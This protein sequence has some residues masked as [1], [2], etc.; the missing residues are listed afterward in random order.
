VW[1]TPLLKVASPASAA[2]DVDDGADGQQQLLSRLNAVMSASAADD[3]VGGQQ[4]LPSPR[5]SQHAAATVLSASSCGTPPAVEDE[6]KAEASVGARP[7]VLSTSDS[8]GGP[9]MAEG[10]GN[11]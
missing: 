8:R 6:F 7:V 2:S 10:F 11:A 3:D 9:R 4:Q 1:D 5:L